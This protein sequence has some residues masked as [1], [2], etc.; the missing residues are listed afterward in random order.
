M[1]YNNGFSILIW[2]KPDCVLLQNLDICGKD[3]ITKELLQDACTLLGIRWNVD[4]S[5]VTINHTVYAFGYTLRFT[6]SNSTIRNALGD[7]QDH[8]EF[9][10]GSSANTAEDL[11]RYKRCKQKWKVPEST[12]H[13]SGWA[14]D[15]QAETSRQPKYKK[16]S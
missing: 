8:V 12:D 14:T 4:I 2:V 3:E 15:Q 11:E 9:I 1:S 6:A 5:L 7:L 13:S 16:F 10:R